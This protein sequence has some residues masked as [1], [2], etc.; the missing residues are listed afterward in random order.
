M[1]DM[2]PVDFLDMGGSHQLMGCEFA[3]VGSLDAAAFGV[4]GLFPAADLDLPVFEIPHD[5]LQGI[6]S[7]KRSRC[8]S[9]L[10]SGEDRNGVTE[11]SDAP[12]EAASVPPLQADAPH[13]P[14]PE[15]RRIWCVLLPHRVQIHRIRRAALT[16]APT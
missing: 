13:D 11:R 16:P 5:G 7:F 6:G 2:P 4:R 1:G 12:G 14:G 8:C 15:P 3:G 9:S 10:P